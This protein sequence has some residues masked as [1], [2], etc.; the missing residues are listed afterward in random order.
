M[1]L[2]KTSKK[3][4]ITS[5]FGPDPDAIASCLFT[6][7]IIKTNFP[8]KIL[9]I[10]NEGQVPQS[11]KSLEYFDE[12]VTEDFVNSLS[13]FNPDL[14]IVLDC[15]SIDR[16]SREQSQNARDYIEKNNIKSI[17]I[18]H[19]QIE[20]KDT[21]TIFI[22]DLRTSATET[23]FDYFVL[24]NKLIPYPNMANTVLAGIVAD[25]GRF[26][27]RNN[28]HRETFSI[29][30]EMIDLGGNIEYLDNLTNQFSEIYLRTYTEIL[31]NFKSTNLYNY[32]YLS[33]EFLSSIPE[34]DINYPDVSSA[35]HSA[36]DTFLRNYNGNSWGFV[37]TP[38]VKSGNG[39]YKIS[40]R[41]TNSSNIDTTLF[42][43]PLGGG[44]H[45]PASGAGK[46]KASNIHEMIELIKNTIEKA[47][48]SE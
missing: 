36:T 34:L 15:P 41:A 8:D 33:D 47:L 40:F 29:V 38:D 2:I 24:Q 14:I 17:W 22:N 16:V 45:K 31:S 26:L 32:S 12:I 21:K 42:T 9:K 25:T 13:N 28:F 1:D 6:F 48:Q 20:D 4:L 39:F 5:H 18:D 27:Y 46:I 23:A 3:I 7:G 35:V 44:G 11:L 30:S 37:V 43:K 19:H 10:T